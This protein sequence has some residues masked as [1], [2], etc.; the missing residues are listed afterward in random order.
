MRVLVVALALLAACASPEVAAPPPTP[1]PSPAPAPAPTPQPLPPLVVVLHV[2]TVTELI[3]RD[4][5]WDSPELG[6]GLPALADGG[7]NVIV[8]ALWIPRADPDPR[9]TALRKAD[10]VLQAVERTAGAATLVRDPDELE[11]AL[12]AG[13]LAVVMSLEGGTALVDGEATL[14][15]LRARGLSMIGLTWTEMSPYADSS[16]EQR[17][18]EAA[19]LTPAGRELVVACNRLGL[20]LDVSHMSDEATRDT[21]AVSSAPVVASHSNCRAVRDVPRNLPDDLLRGIAEGGGLV[22]AMFHGP[23]VQDGPAD[24]AGVVE[25]VRALVQR[26]GA[27]HVGIGSDWDGRIKRPRGLSSARDLPALWS[28]LEAAGLD[29]AQLR[30]V[31]GDSFLRTWRQVWAQRAKE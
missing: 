2:D 15:E 24:R 12:R 28:D 23:F 4:L 27:E 31:R 19:G 30:L 8:E 17:A 25:Q 7:V 20:M 21:L 3:A 11:A 16:A 1:A 13:K 26:V 14:R 6:A 22:G 10:R 18:G 9:G 29:S 5:R